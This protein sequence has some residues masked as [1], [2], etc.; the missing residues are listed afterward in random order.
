MKH[1][2]LTI[3]FIFLCATAYG[4]VSIGTRTGFY[5]YSGGGE[6]YNHQ[7]G[8]DSEMGVGLQVEYKEEDLFIRGE[9]ET[10][11][12]G[13]EYSEHLACPYEAVDLKQ[14]IFGFTVGKYWNWF[15]LGA[16]LGVSFN[17]D[18][19]TELYPGYTNEVIIENSLERHIVLGVEYKSCYVEVK[20]LWSEAD[21]FVDGNFNH[22]EDIGFAAIVGGYKWKF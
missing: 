20:K 13:N 1:L 4:E 11:K 8:F 9:W 12:T 10:L 14:D 5:Q 22:T 17:G 6:E 21:V 19:Y 2:I 15:Y 18:T 16:G 7:G 3:C